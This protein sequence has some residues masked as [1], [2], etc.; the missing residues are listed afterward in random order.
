MFLVDALMCL[1]LNV[2]FEAR[3]Q[4]PAGQIAVVHVVLNRV[5]SDQF[6]DD[7]CAVVKDAYTYRSGLPQRDRCQ[8]SWYCDGKSDEPT[9]HAALLKAMRIVADMIKFDVSD[10]TY[11]AT[12]YHSVHVSPKWAAL[13][14]RIVRIDDHI[15]Y[16]DYP[17]SK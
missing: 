16:K 11:G 4:S 7:P 1:V 15:F 9:D 2:Y 10:P 5:K 14:Q 13:K 6:P 12:H 8:F 17:A 3:N